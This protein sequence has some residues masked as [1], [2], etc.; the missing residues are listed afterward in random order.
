MGR[1]E[2]R[3]LNDDVIW[4]LDRMA[5]KRG[6]SRS[7]LV[8][9]I[10]TDFTLAGEVKAAEDKYGNLVHVMTEVAINTTT[11]LGEINEKLDWLMRGRAE[12]NEKDF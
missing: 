5:K 9:N 2:V 10:I 8:R 7:E 1:I 12:S 4:K 3:N 6:M 11:E